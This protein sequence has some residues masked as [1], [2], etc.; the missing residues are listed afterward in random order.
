M[1]GHNLVGRIATDMDFHDASARR[2]Y[3][4]GFF[5][6]LERLIYAQ[7]VQREVFADLDAFEVCPDLSPGAASSAGS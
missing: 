2:G 5:S 4:I 3:W 6:Y 1:V 7:A